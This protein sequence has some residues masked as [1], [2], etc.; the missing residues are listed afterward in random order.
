LKHARRVVCQWVSALQPDGVQVVLLDVVRP[1]DQR[2]DVVTNVCSQDAS[3]SV[4][5]LKKEE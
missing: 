1:R 4:V 3:W 2:L 5:G